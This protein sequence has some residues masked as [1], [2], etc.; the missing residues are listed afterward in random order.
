VGLYVET[1]DRLTVYQPDPRRLD[2]PAWTFPQSDLTHRRQ[3]E[4]WLGWTKLL[5]QLIQRPR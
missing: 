3:T 2:H 5:D 1:T 4:P